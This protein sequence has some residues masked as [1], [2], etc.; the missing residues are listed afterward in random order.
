LPHL[1]F[2]LQHMLGLIQ[3]AA[4]NGR[5]AIQHLYAAVDLLEGE[6]AMLPIE[7][8]RTAFMDD[9]QEIY[10]DLLAALL[11][12][13]DELQQKGDI[14]QVD[15]RVAAAFAVSERARSRT[16]LERL[17]SSLNDENEETAQQRAPSTQAEL[18]QATA[19]RRQ[20][21][22]LYNQV[23][24]EDGNRVLDAQASQR[25]QTQE[26]ALQRLEW[27]LSSDWQMT[28]WR[29]SPWWSQ[30]QTVDLATFQQALAIDQ[31][32]VIYLILHQEVATLL[33]DRRQ[34]L[35]C[36][37]LC[38]V[39]ALERAQSELRFQLGRVEVGAEGRSRRAGRLQEAAQRILQHLYQM[40]IAPLAEHL[41]SPRLL[42]IPQGSLH[43]LPFHAL[44]DGSQY[45][46]QRFECTY[47]PS[48]SIV[49][50]QRTQEIDSSFRSWAGL[51]LS[52]PAI[53]A[54]EQEVRQAARYFA[55]AEI[56]FDEQANR[57]ALTSAASQVDV[58]HIAT[59]GLFR[60]DNPFFSAFKL[61]DGWIDVREL[62]RLPLKARLVV[63]SA[64]ESGASQV[65]GSDEAI[66]LAR[67]LLGAGARQLVVSLWNVH[68][69]SSAAL[70]E[71]FYAYLMAHD[72][73]AAT[74]LEAK[75]AAQAL[76]AAQLAAIEAQAH[77]YFWAP[78]LVIGE[79]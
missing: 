2:K 31:Q 26:A 62:Y 18:Q 27:R 24:G 49:G 4:G 43:L 9:K 28:T 66:G 39:D 41:H 23:L 12:G 33:V 35:V 75:A 73:E 14:D 36:R 71:R 32:A 37:R 53:P 44:W 22:W 48:A 17:Q 64:C 46:V 68:D 20:L 72:Q 54:A 13:N 61:A 60:P 45:L 3:Q 19:L 42:F 70:M 40:L 25:L 38:T 7:E 21:H 1:Y 63:L 65:R 34:A 5:D 77:P 50:L 30:V 76:R 52:D 78:F 55:Q 29:Q 57:N 74:G 51:A 10:A 47:A 8:V 56:Y 67:G 58:L 6:R 15:Q 59:H 69:A 16:L 79:N 11:S